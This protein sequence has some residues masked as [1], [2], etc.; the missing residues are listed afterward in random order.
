MLNEK[1]LL[2]I[3]QSGRTVK[4]YEIHIPH[5]KLKEAILIPDINPRAQNVLSEHNTHQLIESL[6][7]G[8]ERN[9]FGQLLP[10]GR[11]LAWDG[12]RRTYAARLAEVGL[13]F[14]VTTESDI[15]AVDI[16]AVIRKINLQE[17]QSIYD[18][19]LQYQS[20]KHKYKYTN[21]ELAK[22]IK[23][24][25]GVITKYLK[26]LDIPA[27]FISIFPVTNELTYRDLVNLLLIKNKL[28]KLDLN[29]DNFL[30]QL[31]IEIGTPKEVILNK[32][33]ISLAALSHNDTDTED[34]EDAAL[35]VRFKLT[36][37]HNQ[38]YSCTVNKL[39]EE[40]KKKLEIFLNE[41][42]Q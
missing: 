17:K 18:T 6:K 15:S 41:L 11:I 28:D 7:T 22:A 36:D 31:D 10:D 38:T 29:Y 13:N 30:E 37:K 34:A 8:Q 25:K 14:S 9:C 42:N 21:V 3:M 20:L 26:L 16:T 23:V 5:D 39:T 24:S 32:I 2:K 35:K 33:K 19:A 40:K 1:P 12:S 4:F 27:C